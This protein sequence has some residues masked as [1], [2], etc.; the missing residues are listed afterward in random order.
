MEK[1]LN[2]LFLKK[3]KPLFKNS[4]QWIYNLRRLIL[5]A[6]FKSEYGAKKVLRYDPIPGTYIG[7]IELKPNDTSWAT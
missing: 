5:F 2:D 6:F 1:V 4:Y 3:E 7:E